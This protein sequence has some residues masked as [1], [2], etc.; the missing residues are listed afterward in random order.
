METET[1]VATEMVETVNDE[2]D[3]K[4]MEMAEMMR[5]AVGNWNGQ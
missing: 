5:K 3:G 4:T 2:E 1:E